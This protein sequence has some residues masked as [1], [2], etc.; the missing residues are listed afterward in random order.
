MGKCVTWRK[1][2]GNGV[3]DHVGCGLPRSFEFSI[4]LVF[5]S[6]LGACKRALPSYA[7]LAM[8][9][10]PYSRLTLLLGHSGRA[11][12]YSTRGASLA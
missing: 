10:L 4:G 11:S 5:G 8:V 2:P 7:P 3:L 6:R 12:A 9:F 1:V